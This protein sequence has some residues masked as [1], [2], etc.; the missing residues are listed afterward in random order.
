[1]FMRQAYGS[2]AGVGDTKEALVMA[3]GI[4]VPLV[5][6]RAYVL[7]AKPSLFGHEVVG[8]TD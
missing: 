5:L 3:T 4:L 8:K 7:F 2:N 6:F 1:M